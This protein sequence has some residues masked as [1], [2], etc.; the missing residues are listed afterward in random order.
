MNRRLAAIWLCAVVRLGFYA[1]MLPMWEGFDEWAHFAVIRAVASGQALPPRDL[2]VPPDIEASLQQAPVPWEMR[3]MSAPFATQDVYWAFPAE[4]RHE[5]EIAFAHG[6]AAP[7]AVALSAYEA[8]QA[9]LYYWLM[10]PVVWLLS[11]LG[12]AVQVMAVRWLSALIA[13][14]VIP[15]VYAIGQEIFDDENLALGCAAVAA[16]MPEFALDVARVGN[17]CLAVPLF[18]LVIWL[19]LRVI[20]LGLSYRRA[21]W[22][23]LALGA[24]LLTKAYFLAALP[25]VALLLAREVWRGQKK[26][27]PALLAV[28]TSIAVAGWWYA[29]NLF[30]TGTLTGL[31][32]AVQLRQ[33]GWR[34]MLQ[35]AVRV[36]W[37]KAIDGVLLSHLYFGGWS[38]LTV[39]SWMYHVLYAVALAGAIGVTTRLRRPAIWWLLAVY[40]GVWIGQFY[41]IVLLFLA[42]GVA[43]SMGWYLYAVLGAEVTLCTVGLRR[44]LGQGATVLGTVLFGLLDLYTV[45]AVAIPYYTGMIRHKASGA[46]ELV[47]FGKFG[48]FGLVGI[49]GRLA[50]YKGPLI[51]PGILETLWV[52]YVASTVWLMVAHVRRPQGPLQRGRQDNL[53]ANTLT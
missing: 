36:P 9:P 14:S 46:L 51:L 17:D 29:R 28:A 19:G 4:Q 25:G 20:R 32:E 26:L 24:G 38:S 23:G 35:G 48:V 33:D 40:L 11:G 39:R 21:A 22:L 45:N 1:A 34:S 15:L 5:R 49:F 13:A 10:A 27:P 3:G 16:L 50:A 43:T 37:L 47:G 53:G 31:S 12:L 18:T 42:K 6:S 41:N 52:A 44:W 2:G 7:N 8:L 30:T